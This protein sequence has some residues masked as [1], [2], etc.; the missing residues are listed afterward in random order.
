MVTES[1][2]WDPDDSTEQHCNGSMV[3]DHKEWCST[4]LSPPQQQ[5]GVS[6]A[7]VPAAACYCLAMVLS[8]LLLGMFTR[9]LESFLSSATQLP[10]PPAT[11][12]DRRARP[13]CSSRPHLRLRSPG[14]VVQLWIPANSKE[15]HSFNEDVLIKGESNILVLQVY[16]LMTSS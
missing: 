11:T 2:G 7:T 4:H 8:S 16:T 1:L 13:V 6:A 15:N 3:S 10:P 9:T 14:M 12:I 5:C